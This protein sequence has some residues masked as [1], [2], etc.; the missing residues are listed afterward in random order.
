MNNRLAGIRGLLFGL[1]LFVGSGLADASFLG[2][3]LILPAVGRGAGANLSQWYTTVWFHNPSAESADVSV[4]LLMRK[5][6]NPQPTT[7]SITV[8]PHSSVTS[9]DV[10]QDLFGLDSAAGAFGIVSTAPLAVGAR[11]YQSNGT[12]SESQGQYMAGVPVQFA[13]GPGQST[14]VPGI[15]Q[16]ADG[17]FRCN[18]GYVESTGADVELRVTL[19]DGNGVQVASKSY[20][21]G[22]H[23][24]S[25]KTLTDLAP[26]IEIDGGILRFEQTGGS[27]SVLV[28]ASN[29]A[30]GIN[31]QDP[32]TLDPTLELKSGAQPGGDIS[33]IEAGPGLLGGGND[34]V[35]SLEVKPGDGI[36]VN[37]SGVSIKVGGIREEHIASGELLLGIQVQDQVFKDVLQLSAGTNMKLETDGNRIEIS[38][39]GCFGERDETEITS[40]IQT[41][42]AGSLV[43]G[44]D[45]L[46]LPGAGRWRVGYRV[47]AEVRNNRYGSATE[48]VSVALY[49]ATRKEIIKNSISVMA[50]KID[51]L[52]SIFQ[53]LSGEAVIEIDR[54]T[55]IVL[56]ARSTSSDVSLTVQPDEYD[57]SGLFSDPDAASFIFSECMRLPG[58]E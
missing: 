30:N 22:R 43:K 46:I 50:L 24:A 5:Q 57:I 25:Q 13:I 58:H 29:V 10:L 48:A 40:P 38:T 26:G 8:P 31:S 56:S 23:G 7:R 15:S 2:K 55:T 53:T 3:E 9:T 19:L 54:P 27:G 12:I 11:I 28:Y 45:E 17:S 42:S 1:L 51:L 41:S 16:P 49:D 21:I 14:E 47:F 33:A 35:V 32:T 44:S 36:E 6:S 52:S 18:F 34:G 20:G 4:S 39:L 37:E